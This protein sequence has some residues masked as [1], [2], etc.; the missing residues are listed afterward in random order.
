MSRHLMARF[1]H[2]H[3]ADE[4]GLHFDW[5]PR[6]RGNL[7]GYHAPLENGDLIELHGLPPQRKNEPWKWSYHIM[8]P[9][10]PEV[11]MVGHSGKWSKP[12]V[13]TVTDYPHT[14]PWFGSGGQGDLKAEEEADRRKRTNYTD[15]RQPTMFDNKLDAMRAAE[16]HYIALNRMG[17]GRSSIDSGVDYDDISKP[18]PLDDDYGPIFGSRLAQLSHEEVMRRID[19]QLAA[20]E[21]EDYS[22][23]STD[24]DDDEEHFDSEEDFDD[25]DPNWWDDINP[26][27]NCANCGKRAGD[28]FGGVTANCPVPGHTMVNGF[29]TNKF[30]PN[31]SFTRSAR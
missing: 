14:R 23:Y 1:R 10:D 31:S 17:Q 25:P 11:K 6:S 19:E 28:H 22:D 3:A 18:A 5:Q 20:G 21:P 13:W 12:G 7:E 15:G 26:D 24:Y 8:G 27:E 30:D 2:L 16:Q 29:M 9:P 4:N